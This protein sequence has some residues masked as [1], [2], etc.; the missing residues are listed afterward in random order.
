[1]K[2]SQKAFTIAELVVV[3][4]ILAILTT[5]W[6]VSFS[7]YSS[8]VR[9]SNRIAQLTGISTSLG[10]YNIKNF[11]PLPDNYI[12]LE[13]N[14]EDIWYQWFAWNDLLE[15][16]D[17]KKW[18]KDPKDDKY[19]TYYVTKKRSSF[20]L[21][22]FLSSDKSISWLNF[23]NKSYWYT[24]DYT[25]RIPYLEGKRLWIL[26]EPVTNIPIQE[27][28][29]LIATKKL[30]LG[31]T[32]DI[33]KA[34][35]NNDDT[36]EWDFTVLSEL[37]ISTL[38]WGKWCTWEGG[39]IL[40]DYDYPDYITLVWDDILWRTWTD[41][42][43]ARYCNDYRNPTWLYKYTGDIWDWVYWV[44]PALNWTWFKVW[45][46]MTTDWWGWTYATMIADTVEQNLFDLWNTSKITSLT[47]SI[48]DKWQIDDIW[49]EAWDKDI[50]LKCLTDK[51][52][53]MQQYEIPFIIYWFKYADIWDLTKNN[54]EGNQL[55]SINLTAK[56]NWNTYTL[57]RNYW[58]S[59]TAESHYFTI[60][61][62]SW[63]SWRLFVI[64]DWNKL[65]FKNSYY[66]NSPAY[67]NSWDDEEV[68]SSTTYC[69]TAIR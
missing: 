54:K 21:L 8:W 58:D 53:E 22:W 29:S 10:V 45:C 51:V 39:V 27:I 36:V 57:D 69:M 40:C 13:V 63:S 68:L 3:I 31:I 15:E 67:D 33:Y 18:W 5:L 66:P 9:D 37:K 12:L 6:F 55:S 61:W 56:W 32:T 35:L 42:S 38:V 26:V 62:D 34:Y 4:I 16:I 11:L 49:R 28:E 41:L 25:N 30:D 52:N 50:M 47:S 17:Y 2:S 1:M 64:L 7:W 20:Q 19:Y 59:W 23:T 48:S 43:I 46:D 14:W 24:V 65:K 44:D 60:N